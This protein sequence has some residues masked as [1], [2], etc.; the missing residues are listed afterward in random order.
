MIRLFS[1]E[2]L[3]GVGC[4]IVAR[5]YFGANVDIDYCNHAM[6]NSL[7]EEMCVTGTFKDYEKI[8][9]TD[10]SVNEEIA[11]LIE[12]TC[13]D[14]VLLLDH[15]VSAMWLNNYNWAKV[16]IEHQN[17]QKACGSSLFFSY[18]SL[19][20]D[21][22]MP[23]KVWDTLKMFV[24]RVR[25]FDT[26][27]WVEHNDLN[28]KA[29]ADLQRITDKQAFEKSMIEKIFRVNSIE[30][31]Y[32]ENLL[33]KNEQERIIRYLQGYTDDKVYRI[34]YLNSKVGVVFA[35]QNTSELG[36]YLVKNYEN[37]FDFIVLV[38]LSQ[39]TFSYVRGNKGAMNLGE[40]AKLRGGGGHEKAAGSPIKDE[41]I[42]ELL[43]VLFF[44]FK[45]GG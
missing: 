20:H 26:W 39:K 29:L 31:S 24:E 15:H 23:E 6:V 8:Y 9:I 13:K 44:D 45:M 38:N 28:A 1:H 33:L 43:N 7:V 21:N 4:G 42:K 18:L 5:A 41:T 10:I 16:R 36:N 17:G 32:E 40:V 11:E 22:P 19:T 37:E 14:R 12:E 25:M 34:N 35:E 3:D 2:D 27:D 30:F